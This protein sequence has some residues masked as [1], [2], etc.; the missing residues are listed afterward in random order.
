MRKKRNTN[1]CLDIQGS[2]EDYYQL[3]TPLQLARTMLDKPKSAK[4]FY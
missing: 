4:Y 3:K 1:E 2:M